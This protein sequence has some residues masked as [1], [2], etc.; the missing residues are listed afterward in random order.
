MVTS[1]FSSLSFLNMFGCDSK[2]SEIYAFTHDIYV[3]YTQFL[4]YTE[5][6]NFLSHPGNNFEFMTLFLF[7]SIIGNWE[8]LGWDVM[9]ELFLKLLPIPSSN[10]TRQIK[11]TSVTSSIVTDF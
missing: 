8:T 4:K 10:L 6:I 7:T 1:E 9:H 5:L 3:L 2:I 11:K